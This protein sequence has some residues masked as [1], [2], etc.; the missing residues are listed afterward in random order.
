[1]D[2]AIP[3]KLANIDPKNGAPTWATH[4]TALFAIAGVL[5]SLLDVK[6]VLGTISFSVFFLLW[7]Y[8]LSAMLL[9]Y[10]RPD[11]YEKSPIK[12]K[13][14][15]LPLITVLG[16]FTFAI[17][18]FIIFFTAKEITTPI[19][20]TLVS[21]M[22]AGMALYFVQQSKNIKKGIDIPQIYSQIPPE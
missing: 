13:F 19:A 7:L 10:R 14:L 3:E 11:I 17:G 22:T 21:I 6:V 2:R 9:P 18:W 20:I 16:F 15:G 5:L 4:L 1:M 12:L 8:G